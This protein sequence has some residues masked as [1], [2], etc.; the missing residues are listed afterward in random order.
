MPVDAI[1]DGASAEYL[2]KTGQ[3]GDLEFILTHIDDLDEIY[4]FE[5]SELVKLAVEQLVGE[6]A[7]APLWELFG[8]I[9]KGI[10]WIPRCPSSLSLEVT[11]GSDTAC[12]VVRVVWA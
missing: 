5:R 8:P 6:S 2:R 12:H 11:K 1:V 10:R 7:G 9:L 4:R 3:S